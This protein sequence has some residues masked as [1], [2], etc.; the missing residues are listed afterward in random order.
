[1][2]ELEFENLGVL[3]SGTLALNDL[4]L[5]C[6]EN[7]TGKTTLTYTLYALLQKWQQYLTLPQFDVSPLHEHGV[8]EIDLS[9]IQQDAAIF[10]D[11]MLGQYFTDMHEYLGMPEERFQHTNLNLKMRFDSML[12]VEQEGIV[13]IG[14][15][16]VLQYRKHTTSPILRLSTTDKSLPNAYFTF[17]YLVDAIIRGLCF[18]PLFPTPFLISTE[19]T[20]TI[21]FLTDI[22][23]SQRNKEARPLPIQDNIDFLIQL[24]D[25]QNQ[26]SF[27]AETAPEI[28]EEFED[29][30]GGAFSTQDRVIFFAPK[31]AKGVY[32]RMPESSSSVRSLVHLSYYLKHKAK[33]GD[34]LIIDE[35]ELNLHPANQRKLARLLVRLVNAGIKVLATTHSDYIGKEINTLIMLNQ[36]LPYLERIRKEFNYTEADHIDPE[37]VSLYMIRPAKILKRGSKR[38]TDGLKLELAPQTTSLGI[39]VPTFDVT[40]DAMNAVQDAIYYDAPDEVPVQ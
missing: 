39:E 34:L 20:G 24:E 40:I 22:L 37:K 33:K 18:K 12:V 4:T 28:L 38:R 8:M 31:S 36:D 32:L 26:K 2:F 23:L 9:P 10:I 16:T 3:D 1:V 7:N 27:I 13:N 35:P 14:L 29:L 17:D 19:R 6:G 30:L 15:D 25:I 5:I 11:Y 21:T